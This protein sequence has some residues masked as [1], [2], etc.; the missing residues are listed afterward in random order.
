MPRKPR[1]Q[2]MEKCPFC[3]DGGKP[4]I[5]RSTGNRLCWGACAKCHTQ[6]PPRGTENGA[7]VAWNTRYREPRKPRV[8]KKTVPVASEG[9]AHDED[10][11]EQE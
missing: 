3:I 9:D 2:N 10:T 4:I 11:R 6:G 5:E 7:V 1:R 8:A